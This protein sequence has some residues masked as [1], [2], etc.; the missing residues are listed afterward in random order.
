MLKTNEVS[1]NS[2]AVSAKT[3]LMQT[4]HFRAQTLLSCGQWFMSHSDIFFPSFSHHKFVQISFLLP[5]YSA[6]Y[7]CSLFWRNFNVWTFLIPRAPINYASV[8][9]NKLYIALDWGL[10]FENNKEYQIAKSF[11]EIKCLRLSVRNNF[12]WQFDTASEF[13]LG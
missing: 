8:T 9:R 12:Q 2:Q 7:F 5:V 3:Y 1:G 4:L 13:F 11:S 10:I 6:F